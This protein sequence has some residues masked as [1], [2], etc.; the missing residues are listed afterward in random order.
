MYG[1]HVLRILRLAL[2]AVLAFLVVALCYPES[3]PSGKPVL[4]IVGLLA[5]GV[6]ARRVGSQAWFSP[7]G[8]SR[9]VTGG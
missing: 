3:W 1:Q 7:I 4:A 8:R 2:S 6:P 5:A 9:P